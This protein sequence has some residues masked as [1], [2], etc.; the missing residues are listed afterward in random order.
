MDAVEFRQH[1]RELVDWMADYMGKVKELPVRSKLEPGEVEARLPDEPPGKGEPMEEIFRD[2]Q[3]VVMPGITHWQHPR[4][5]G[6]F[7]A[8][9]SPPSVLAEML[10][11][12][13]GAQ[14][15]TWETSPTGT[16]LETRTLEWLRRMIGLP[17]GFEGVIQDSASSASL[18]ALLMARERASEWQGNQRGLTGLGPFTIYISQETHSS[19]EKD[20]MIAGF[21]LDNLRKVP[22]NGTFAMDPAQLVKMIRKDQE[23]GLTPACVVA[24]LGTTA[25]GAIDPLGPIA[26]ICRRE[27]VFLHVDAAWAGAA[28]VLEDFRWMIEG[29]EHVDSFVF[30]PHKWMFTNFDCSAHYVRSVEDLE[31]T[32]SVFPEYLKGG[33]QGGAIEYRNRSVPLG[34]RFRA[35]KLWFVIRSYGVEG[36]R[37][38]ISDHIRM[39][40][41][42]E[43][44]IDGTDG[45]ELTAPRSLS[46]VNFR[47]QPDALLD[48]EELDRMN[49]EILCR[50]NRSGI[51]YLSSCRIQEK[52]SIRFA[53]GQRSTRTH[54]IEKTWEA[55]QETAK[56]LD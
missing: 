30:N 14:C 22:T 7:P 29:V 43:S 50:V 15:M 35:L 48:G 53:I 55:V 31:R 49:E 8:N 51:A 42:L 10:T 39:A 5:F 17:K 12:S 2:F 11:A 24:T 36:L 47:F 4:F 41:S 38:M 56:G 9:N 46:L 3:E 27:G 19:I 32:L 16:E 40:E 33:S 45:F 13:L 6:F 21:G 20:A 34:R 54:D 25:V 52:F 26:E 28:L 18:V 37:R 23:A 44:W 1:G